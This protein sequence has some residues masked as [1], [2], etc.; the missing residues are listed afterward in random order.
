MV[1]K[2]MGLMVALLV[3]GMAVPQ[4]RVRIIEGVSPVTNRVKAATVPSKL[5]SMANQ[6]E[7][8]IR[9]RGPLAGGEGPW[10]GWLRTTYSGAPEDPWGNLY[11]LDMGRRGGFTVGSM[12]ADG[13]KD[14]TDDITEERVQER[15]R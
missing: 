10:R 11:Y 6:L 8:R 13:E 9:T 5:A 2:V 1:M 14:T 15:R 7:I 4:T 12:G 3:V